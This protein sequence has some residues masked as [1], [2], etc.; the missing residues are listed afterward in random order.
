MHESHNQT[1]MNVKTFLC[2]EGKKNNSTR[3]QHNL[4]NISRAPVSIIPDTEPSAMFYDILTQNY[5]L[6]M[7]VIFILHMMLIL[8]IS[9]Y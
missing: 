2:N 1:V 9:H 7:S 5:F 6:G 4:N 8:V 3:F